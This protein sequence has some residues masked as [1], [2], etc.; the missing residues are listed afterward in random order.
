MLNLA[1]FSKNP[2]HH[3]RI[4]ADLFGSGG[5]TDA[6]HDVGIDGEL[7]IASTVP[8]PNVPTARLTGGKLLISGTPGQDYILV[9]LLSPTEVRVRVNST[10][11]GTF[12]IPT[13]INT[14]DPIGQDFIYVSPELPRPNTQ[15]RSIRGINDDQSSGGEATDIADGS[16]L[17]DLA[18][19]GYLAD[20]SERR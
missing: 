14:S 4:N 7:T 17:Q 16:W 15:P 5:P 19:L 10:L 1:A 13:Q 18:L 3:G 2:E 6:P 12:A 8:D 9:A 20:L 11:L